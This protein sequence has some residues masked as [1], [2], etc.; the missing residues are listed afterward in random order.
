LILFKKESGG[1]AAKGS[2]VSALFGQITCFYWKSFT[3]DEEGTC[4]A[5][6]L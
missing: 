4:L 3:D 5:Y 1:G 2:F 6:S